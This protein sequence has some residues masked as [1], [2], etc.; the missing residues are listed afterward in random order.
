MHTHLKD[1]YPHEVIQYP[2]WT[3]LI[4]TTKCDVPTKSSEPI[5]SELPC[6]L[7]KTLYSSLKD[8]KREKENYKVIQRIY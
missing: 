8:L 4:M 7:R 3:H 6:H 1:E 5:S 2:I